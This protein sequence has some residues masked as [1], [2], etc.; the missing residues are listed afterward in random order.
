[1][2]SHIRY[3]MQFSIMKDYRAAEDKL[4]FKMLEE[5]RELRD[6]YEEFVAQE[7]IAVIEFC[8]DTEIDLT[9]ESP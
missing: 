4:V 7:E 6:K 5:L 3:D 9:H 1:V 8:A 2:R